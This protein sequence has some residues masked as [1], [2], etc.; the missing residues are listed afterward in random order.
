MNETH[1]R[2]HARMLLESCRNGEFS[3][4]EV[5]EYVLM[6]WMDAGEAEELACGEYN[7]GDKDMGPGDAWV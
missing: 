2:R 1:D 7:M 6:D 5:L 3:A 4:Q